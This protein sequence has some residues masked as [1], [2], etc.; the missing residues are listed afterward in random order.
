MVDVSVAV[1]GIVLVTL[2]PFVMV[3][4]WDDL[5]SGLNSSLTLGVKAEVHAR[6]VDRIIAL[7]A[8]YLLV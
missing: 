3:L 5:E 2:R 6:R 8:S 4:P 7:W 1:L